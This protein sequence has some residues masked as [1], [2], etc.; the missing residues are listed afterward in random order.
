MSGVANAM[1]LVVTIHP[2]NVHHVRNKES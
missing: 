2:I 1:V